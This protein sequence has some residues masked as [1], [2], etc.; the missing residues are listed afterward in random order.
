MDTPG[1][2][3]SYKGHEETVKKIARKLQ[4][5]RVRMILM[6]VKSTYEGK[7]MFD[8]VTQELFRTFIEMFGTEKWTNFGVLLTHVDHSKQGWKANLKMAEQRTRE[9]IEK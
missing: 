4:G 9:Y 2:I 1:L 8:S 3:S 5:K 6:L 7:V